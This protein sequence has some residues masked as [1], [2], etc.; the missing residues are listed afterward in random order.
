VVS[1]YGVVEAENVR[2]ASEPSSRM[3]NAS[4]PTLEQREDDIPVIVARVGGAAEL[5]SSGA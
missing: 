2:T 3:S 4:P 1:R 5:N